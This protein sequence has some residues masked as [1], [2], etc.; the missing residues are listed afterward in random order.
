MLFMFFMARFEDTDMKRI[1]LIAA[2]VL[3][4]A[5]AMTAQ[6]QQAPA[7]KPEQ[8]P[9]EKKAPLSVAGKWNVELN[10]AMGQSTPVLDLKQDGQK[11]TGTYSGRYGLAPVVG[12]LKDNAI[13]LKISIN[14]EGTDVEA[15]YTGEVAAD[16]QTM[17]GTAT[18]GPAGDATW[19]AR[20]QKT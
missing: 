10:S 7:Q 2:A 14:A 1:L 15:W 3:S 17:K 5:G 13:E 9:E 8:K 20:K 12:T 11:I 19:L 4:L 6:S 16:G 18:L